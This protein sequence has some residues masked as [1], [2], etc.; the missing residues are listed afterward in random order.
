MIDS[1][2]ERIALGLLVLVGLAFVAY[3]WVV[4]VAPELARIGASLGPR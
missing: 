4:A 3:F 1:C 2:R